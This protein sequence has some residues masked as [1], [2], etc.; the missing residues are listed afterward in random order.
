MRL[1]F[2]ARLSP[3]V[4]IRGV[5]DPAAACELLIDVQVHRQGG[6]SLACLLACSPA[7]TIQAFLHIA[8]RMVY[9][10]AVSIV[11]AVANVCFGLQGGY[12]SSANNCLTRRTVCLHNLAFTSHRTVLSRAF[13]LLLLRCMLAVYLS[14]AAINSWCMSLIV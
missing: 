3:P 8:V 14:W 6:C 12:A 13:I 4:V 9:A 1:A 5:T 7:Q 11:I 2:K 10:A